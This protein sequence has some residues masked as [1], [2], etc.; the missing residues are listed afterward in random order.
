MD[1]APKPRTKVLKNGAVYDLDRKRIVANPGGG[2]AAFGTQQAAMARERKAELK[3]ETIAAAANEAVERRGYGKRYGSLA[4]VAE[5]A[6]VMQRKATTQDDPKAVD[7]ARFLLQETGLSDKQAQ[8][9]PQVQRV[10]YG[11]DAPTLALLRQALAVKA[12]D[13]RHYQ[14]HEVEGE[15]AE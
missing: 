3:R 4:F 10:E 7:A 5:I 1:E 13:N 9:E 14:Q 11:I 12:R 6:S 15:V 8:A 2:T